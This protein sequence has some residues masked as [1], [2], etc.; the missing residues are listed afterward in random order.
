MKCLSCNAQFNKGIEVIVGYDNEEDDE[1]TII[2]C[3]ICKS[4]DID[5]DEE[6]DD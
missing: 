6:D 4:D 3:P 2:T 5:F 1:I